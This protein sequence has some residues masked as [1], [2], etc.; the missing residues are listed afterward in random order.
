MANEV[1]TQQQGYLNDPKTQVLE[2]PG[3]RILVS[4]EL[5]RKYCVRGRPELVTDNELLLVLSKCRL[6]QLNPFAGEVYV[7]KYTADD[8]A[9]FIVGIDALR[10]RARAHPLELWVSSS[11]GS[12]SVN[13]D[14]E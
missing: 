4:A 7:I 13:P 10:A 8:P 11:S 12:K 3:G 9:S 1:Q 14:N 2:V 5:I 6:L